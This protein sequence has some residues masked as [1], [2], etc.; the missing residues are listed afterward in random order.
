MPS[1]SKKKGAGFEREIATF[2]SELYGESF[3]RVPNSGAYIGGANSKRKVLLDDNQIKS[4]K[5]DIIA[6][7]SWCKFNSECK[8]YSDFAFHQLFSGTNRQLESWIQQCM[9][10]ADHNDFSI[11]FMKF[12]HKGTFVAFPSR[13]QSKFVLANHLIY[14][15]NQFGTWIITDFQQFFQHNKDQIKEVCQTQC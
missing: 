12:N 3:V 15:S 2:L 10:V 1:A 8:N 5:G 14:F 13:W 11:L 6:P 7:D 4:F 9:A